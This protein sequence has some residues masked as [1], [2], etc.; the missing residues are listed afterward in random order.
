V[1]GPRGFGSVEGDT[2]VRCRRPQPPHKDPA[3][4]IHTARVTPPGC[5]LTVRASTRKPS[6]A[7]AARR[8]SA[9]CPALRESLRP[10]QSPRISMP[11]PPCLAS[12]CP[13]RARNSTEDARTVHTVYCPPIARVATAVTCA[14]LSIN[15]EAIPRFGIGIAHG[16]TQMTP[17]QSTAAR[18]AR[19]W[20]RPSRQR[21]S[22]GLLH[23]PQA[24]ATVVETLASSRLFS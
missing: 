24:G 20:S 18:S 2:G 21:F 4:R 14:Q 10:E 1:R 6:A 17:R 12:R 8:A 3:R 7:S 16:R 15:R 19:L 13:G 23:M 11:S 9:T 22:S 5:I